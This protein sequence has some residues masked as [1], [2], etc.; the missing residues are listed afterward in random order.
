MK[1]IW[2]TSLFIPR[3]KFHGLLFHFKNIENIFDATKKEL[4]ELGLTNEE[5]NRLKNP[6]HKKIETDLT[7]CKQ[8]SCEIMTWN[9]EDYPPL[10]KEIHNPPLVLFIQGDK[11]LLSK[12]QL[13]IV[14]SRNPS[15]TGKETAVEFARYLSNTDLIITSGLAAGIDAA[16]HEGAL[17]SENGKTIAITGTGLNYIYPHY[18][19]T[20]AEKIKQRG[21]LVSEFSPHT[22]ATPKNFPQR[23]RIIS[24]LSLGVL[25]VEAALKSGSLI[26]A[27][28]ALEQGREIFAVP[29][30]IHNPLSRGCHQLIQQGAKLVETA[31]DILE[32]L[33]ALYA[34][35]QQ[36]THGEISLDQAKYASTEGT[37]SQLLQYIAFETTAFDIILE[38]SGLTTSEV[39]SMLLSLELTGYIKKVMGGYTRIKGK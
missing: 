24:G 25:V 12:P 21:A 13:A 23:N 19:Q 9:D 31:E 2:L 16:S 34:F 15:H 3:K 30:S 38:R 36:K 5:I 4:Q 7:W 8:N 10:L 39:S 26:T 22:E 17:L 6:D 20:L 33:G 1:N 18:H 28:A 11:T 27:H 29:G 35:I 32:E 37:P 14:G